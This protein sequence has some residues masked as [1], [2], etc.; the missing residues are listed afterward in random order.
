MNPD[1]LKH[2]MNV[3]RNGLTSDPTTGKQVRSGLQPVTGAQSLPCLLEGLPTKGRASILGRVSGAKYHITWMGTVSLREGDIAGGFAG[4]NVPQ[5]AQGKNFKLVEITDDTGRPD[6]AY[7][8]AI[9]AE[10]Q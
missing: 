2:R 9:L 3:S 4:A 1:K 8:S 10:L 7:Y 5:G 6:R